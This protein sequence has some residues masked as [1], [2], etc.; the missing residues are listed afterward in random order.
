MPTDRKAKTIDDLNSVMENCSIVIATDY[1]G[2]DVAEMTMLR[3]VL[4]EQGMKFKVVKNTLLKIAAEQSSWPE[5]QTLPD[6]QTG[7]VFG[8]GEVQDTAK[9]II[10]YIKNSGSQLKLKSSVM[11][12][13][14]LTLTELEY[15]ASLPG[16]DELRAKLVYTLNAPIT[17][18]ARALNSPITNLAQVLNAHVQQN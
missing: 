5:L 11:G 10:R 18:M 17:R 15:L 12:S 2:V 8:Y 6:G 1:S 3:S 14:V 4:R 7:M 13:Q 16:Q 9:V